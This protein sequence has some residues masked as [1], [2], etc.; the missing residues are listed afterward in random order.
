MFDT[1][2]LSLFLKMIKTNTSNTNVI[3]SNLIGN[4]CYLFGVCGHTVN[5]YGLWTVTANQTLVES[6]TTDYTY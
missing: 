4:T 2:Q 1:D 6:L 3:V 5:G